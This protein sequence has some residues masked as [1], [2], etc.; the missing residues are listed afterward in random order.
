MLTRRVKTGKIETRVLL[1]GMWN[2]VAA[3]ALRITKIELS[4]DLAIPLLSAH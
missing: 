2:G 3:V 4:C 1:V